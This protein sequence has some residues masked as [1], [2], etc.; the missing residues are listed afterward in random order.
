[1]Y[2]RANLI[3][4]ETRRNLISLSRGIVRRSG[5]YVGVLSTSKRP[6]GA[7]ISRILFTKQFIS[8]VLK[9]CDNSIGFKFYS[10]GPFML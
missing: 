1:M 6:L 2:V 9:P 7:V 8:L 5:L 4:Q 10:N 3:D